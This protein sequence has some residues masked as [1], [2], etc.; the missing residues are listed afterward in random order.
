M[1]FGLFLDL[2]LRAINVTKAIRVVQIVRSTV[3]QV[4]HTAA[5]P[6]SQ[7]LL[8]AKQDGAHRFAGLNAHSKIIT[9]SVTSRDLDN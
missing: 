5:H 9:V 1:L 6:L 3:T 8:R 7:L 4:N 2:V